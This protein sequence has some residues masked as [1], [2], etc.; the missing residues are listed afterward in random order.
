MGKVQNAEGLWKVAARQNGRKFFKDVIRD[1]QP[2]AE[3]KPLKFVWKLRYPATRRKPCH[4][5]PRALLKGR[6]GET[7]CCGRYRVRRRIETAQI[8]QLEVPEAS[9]L[10]S[11]SLLPLVDRKRA[12]R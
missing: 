4:M 2:F 5:R 6:A 1:A 8:P 11:H 10:V 3:D 9:H 12:R 7:T